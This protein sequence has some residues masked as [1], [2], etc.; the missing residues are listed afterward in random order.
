MCAVSKE[1]DSSLKVP[2][3]DLVLCPMDIALNDWAE[4]CQVLRLL[5]LTQFLH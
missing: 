3:C 2:K 1:A 4:L 5:F